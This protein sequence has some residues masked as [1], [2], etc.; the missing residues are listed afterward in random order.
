[1][2][3]TTRNE[4]KLWLGIERNRSSGSPH[5]EPQFQTHQFREVL[6]LTGLSKCNF[7]V[8]N[9]RKF[10]Y[11]ISNLIHICHMSTLSLRKHFIYNYYIVALLPNK[12]NKN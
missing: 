1:M 3:V 7:R 11:R 6:W 8:N 2:R 9:K 10:L 12:Q 5:L 4:L